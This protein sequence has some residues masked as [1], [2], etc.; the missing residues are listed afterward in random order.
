MPMITATG[1]SSGSHGGE[2][3]N[4]LRQDLS[5]KFCTNCSA[6]SGVDHLYLNHEQQHAAGCDKTDAMLMRGDFRPAGPPAE[7]PL[8]RPLTPLGVSASR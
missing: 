8:R 3:Q 1:A 2:G 5:V 7:F 4:V 6:D